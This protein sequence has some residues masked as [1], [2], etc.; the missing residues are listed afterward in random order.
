MG[1]GGGGG[2]GPWLPILGHYVYKVA[3]F[4]LD[5]HTEC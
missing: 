5:T 1:G 4:I 3:E 2:E